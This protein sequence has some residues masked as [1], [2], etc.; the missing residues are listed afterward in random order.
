MALKKNRNYDIKIQIW[1]EKSKFWLTKSYLWDGQNYDIKSQT[2]DR[3]EMKS[4]T[5]D[6]KVD[7]N[8]KVKIMTKIRNYDILDEI[9]LILKS[10]L[11]HK[12]VEIM[13]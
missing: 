3:F 7:C 2:Y 6:L 4:Q 8:I 11:W 1:D 13:T 12:N 9:S 5:S 10:L